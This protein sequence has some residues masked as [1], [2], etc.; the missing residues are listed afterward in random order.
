MLFNVAEDVRLF[1]AKMEASEVDS[2]NFA[3]LALPA[4]TMCVQRLKLIT[5]STCEGELMARQSS[6]TYQG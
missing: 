5:R 2:M 3:E 1:M 4:E 6:G